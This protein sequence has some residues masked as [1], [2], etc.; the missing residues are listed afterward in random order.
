MIVILGAS[1]AVGRRILPRLL[2]LDDVLGTSRDVEALAEFAGQERFSREPLDLAAPASVE[3]FCQVIGGLEGRLTL[4]NLCS[5]SVDRLLVQLPPQDWA[6]VMD[7][8]LS[9]TLP[10][11]QTAVQAMMRAGWGRII[12]VSSVVAN[13]S[14]VGAGAYSASKAALQALTRTIA[15]EYGRFGITA[16]TIVMGYF[17]TGLIHTLTD[18]K[19][20]EI[21]ARIPSRHFGK[22]E[23]IALAVEYII[24]AGYLNG[25]E[26]RIDGGLQ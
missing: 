6:R 9:R 13:S 5:I 11:M 15:H 4:L 25:A 22:P 21:L 7:V 18:K 16:N 8:N 26:I 2:E 23:E 14:V 12:T 10:L 17:D 3:R 19:R 24:K 1:S 20:N